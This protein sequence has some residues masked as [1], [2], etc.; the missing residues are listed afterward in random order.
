MNNKDFDGINRF[1]WLIVLL[2]GLVFFFNLIGAVY[3]Y[4]FYRNVF[5]NFQKIYMIRMAYLAVMSIIATL[6]AWNILRRV[7]SNQ[8]A[9]INRPRRELYHAIVIPI[10]QE[11]VE[12]LR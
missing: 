5:I 11:S 1:K 2:I 4:S 3:Y 10:Y 9:I 12:L 6:K 7:D 8:K